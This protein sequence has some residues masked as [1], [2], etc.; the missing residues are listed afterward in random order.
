GAIS[1]KWHD[2]GGLGWGT[3]ISNPTWSADGKSMYN[4]FV[5][6]VP[7]S[8]IGAGSEVQVT[9]LRWIKATGKV[10]IETNVRTI[11][12]KSLADFSPAPKGFG[13]SAT[14]ANGPFAA[15]PTSSID[16][17]AGYQLATADTWAG[18]VS[19]PSVSA[20]DQGLWAAYAGG[21]GQDA[22]LGADS[23]IDYS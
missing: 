18:Y 11:T 10:F 4:E 9:R 1:K 17:S 22:A 12:A 2:L 15:A 13:F 14:P 21:F 7:A 6:A 16:D 5:A 19:S 20:V 3:P 8:S 23:V